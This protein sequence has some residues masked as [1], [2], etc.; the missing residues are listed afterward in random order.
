MA[1][2]RS[3]SSSFDAVTPTGRYLLTGQLLSELGLLLQR[4]AQLLLLALQAELHLG[5]RGVGGGGSG[6]GLGA[7]SE[8]PRAHHVA[9][10]RPLGSQRAAAKVKSKR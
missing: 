5:S 6:A 1:Q 7:A 4:A 8:P 10:Q 9:E 2:L 3:V